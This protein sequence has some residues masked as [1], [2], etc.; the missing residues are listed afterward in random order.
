MRRI[1]VLIS[2]IWRL[3]KKALAF[4]VSHGGWGVRV[5]LRHSGTIR[6]L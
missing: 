3:A 5:S 6:M 1:D 4:G 2:C